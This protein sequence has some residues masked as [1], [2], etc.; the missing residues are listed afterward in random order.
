MVVVLNQTIFLKFPLLWRKG[1]RNCSRTFHESVAAQFNRLID[2]SIKIKENRLHC[3]DFMTQVLLMYQ[4][5]MTDCVVVVYEYVPKL[6]VDKN[7]GHYSNSVFDKY[8][9][10]D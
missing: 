3:P 8:N 1:R 9:D 4:I 10:F 5:T 6:L 7:V 2:A